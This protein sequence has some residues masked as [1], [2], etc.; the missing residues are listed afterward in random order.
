[1]LS[2][3]VREG[4]ALF[5]LGLGE[6]PAGRTIG[7]EVTGWYPEV[8]RAVARSELLLYAGRVREGLSERARAEHLALERDD[9]IF[10]AIIYFTSFLIPEFVGSPAPVLAHARRALEISEPIGYAFGVNLAWVGIGIGHSLVGEWQ[11]ARS[12]L[13]RGLELMRAQRAGLFFESRA[14]THLARAEL[15]LGEVERARATIEA[16]VHAGQERHTRLWEIQAH[17]ERARI[18]REIDESGG[19]DEASLSLD[20]AKR[21]IEETGAESLRPQVHEERGRLAHLHGN[22]A[23]RDRELAEAHR[24]YVAIGADG[25]A[26]RLA[27]ELAG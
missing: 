16:A 19:I 7:P 18:L 25:H 6:L 8:A 2:G 27:K 10:V 11:E 23:T 14:L 24:L 26:A 20:A 3:R 1:M 5:E 12:A 9:R 4:L 22:T 13:E 17:L 15:R 21:L